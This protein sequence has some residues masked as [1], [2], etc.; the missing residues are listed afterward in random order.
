MPLMKCR[1]IVLEV[2]A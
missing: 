1:P 2:M